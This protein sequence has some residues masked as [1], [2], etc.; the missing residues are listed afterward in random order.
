MKHTSKL[1][2]LLAVALAL[3]SDACNDPLRVSIPTIVPPGSLSDSA[4]IGTLRAGA[5]GNFSIAFSG[6]HP[7]GSGGT[8][9][10]VIMYGGLLADEWIDSETFPTRIEVDARTIQVTNADVD[11]WYRLLHQARN[12]AEKAAAQYATFL[13]N[14][15][16]HAEMLSLAGYT[17]L[18][19][20][21][22]YCS[23]VP[24]SHLDATTGKITYG[25]PLT[26]RQLIDTAI[27]RFDEALGVAANVTNATLKQTMTNLASVGRARALVDSGD[28]AGAATAVSAVPTSFAY[29]IEHSE[30]STYENNGVFNGNTQDRRYS[31]ADREGGNGFPFRSVIDP[32]TPSRRRTA[33]NRNGFDGL[34]PQYNNFRFG[35][36]KA[37]IPLATGVEARLIEAEAAL[38]ADTANPSAAFFTALN[39]PRA[40][41]ASRSYFNPSPFSRTDTLTN[42]IPALPNLTAADDTTAG[43]AVNLLFNERARWLWLTAHRLGDL[44]RLMRQYARPDSTVFP[45]GAYFKSNPSV[46]G[47]DVNIPVPITEQNNP[48]F[49]ACLDRLP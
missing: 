3:P 11:L 24:V 4:A 27:A 16:G 9:E 41:P 8:G 18:F 45:T 20:A 37:A 26:T 39:D 2:A 15:A 47:P 49:R 25:V 22:T 35:D 38:Q 36:R 10:G 31:V 13:P 19:F 14:D 17:Y 7:D 42:P 23:G 21:E 40:N 5:I 48:N 34:T 43:G 32:R 44:R 46:Y 30:I 6:D 28:F 29:L 1:L 12:A 33:G